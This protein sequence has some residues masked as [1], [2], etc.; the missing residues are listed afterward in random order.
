ML[1]RFRTPGEMADAIYVLVNRPDTVIPG[2]QRWSLFG[3]VWMV[4]KVLG[5]VAA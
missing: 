1:G 5:S 3:R 4:V 2:A